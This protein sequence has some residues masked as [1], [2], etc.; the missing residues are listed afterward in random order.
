MRFYFLFFF[1]FKPLLVAQLPIKSSDKFEL[2]IGCLI[3]FIDHFIA[4]YFVG[5]RT[6]KISQ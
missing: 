5:E 2:E 6:S 1:I 3:L 4:K